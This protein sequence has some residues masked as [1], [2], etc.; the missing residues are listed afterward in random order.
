MDF[1]LTKEGFENWLRRVA[2]ETP[3]RVM[4]VGDSGSCLMANAMLDVTGAQ[5]AAFWHLWGVWNS[6][7]AKPLGQMSPAWALEIA[8]WFDDPRGARCMVLGNRT[9]SAIQTW[10]AYA[11]WQHLDPS[12][13]DPAPIPEAT[14]VS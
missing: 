11:A 6:D 13:S 3:S 5:C 1:P 12:L 14:H 2:T 8:R 4:R 9:P 7:D 10:R